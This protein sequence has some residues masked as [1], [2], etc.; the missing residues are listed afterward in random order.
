MYQEIRDNSAR[1]SGFET[2][3]CL[4][5]RIYNALAPGITVRIERYGREREIVRL[6][7]SMKVRERQRNYKSEREGERKKERERER[8]RV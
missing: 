3:S 4:Q 7:G 6:K 1:I 8:E 5:Q 2:I